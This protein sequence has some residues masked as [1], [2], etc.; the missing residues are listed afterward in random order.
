M[1][2]FKS[3]PKCSG[4]RVCQSDVYGPYIAC[5]ACGHMEYPD[6]SK[7]VETARARKTG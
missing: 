1:F 6:S 5:L 2:L 3:C 7:V 4:D